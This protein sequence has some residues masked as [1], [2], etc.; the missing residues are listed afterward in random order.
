M[1]ERGRGDGGC[2]GD[3]RRGKKTKT[4]K[5][6]PSL[7]ILAPTP[8]PTRP[9]ITC[10]HKG[11][12]MPLRPRQQRDKQAENVASMDRACYTHGEEKGVVCTS[13]NRA[14]LSGTEARLSLYGRRCA[15]I[16]IDEDCQQAVGPIFRVQE[17]D[18]SEKEAFPSKLNN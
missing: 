18:A 7:L 15:C 2:W 3:G 5:K 6:L 8:T 13:M 14:S 4:N 16:Q 10:V 12:E 17:S 9:C 1:E 11:E